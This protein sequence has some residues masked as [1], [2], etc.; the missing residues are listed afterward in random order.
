MFP[1]IAFKLQTDWGKKTPN[2]LA[3]LSNIGVRQ[4]TVNT[5][6]DTELM[7]RSLSLPPKNFRNENTNGETLMLVMFDKRHDIGSVT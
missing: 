1:L 4:A 5:G 2:N 3:H 7:N 6:S